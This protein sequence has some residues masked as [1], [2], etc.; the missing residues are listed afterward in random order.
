MEHASLGKLHQPVREIRRRR[1]NLAGDR[2][3]ATAL[4]A[5]ANLA[6]GLEQGL[7]FVQSFAVGRVGIAQFKTGSLGFLIAGAVVERQIS[8]GNAKGVIDAI[9]AEQEI[10]FLPDMYLGLW[11]EKV[12]GRKLTIWLG[13]CHVHAGIRPADI[14]RWQ[15]EAPDADL[16]VHP[17]CGCASQAMAF[18]NERT[19]ILSTEKMID[20]AK[21]SPKQRFLVAT[22]TGILHRL[23]REAPGKRFEAVRDDAECRYMKLTTLDKVRDSLRDM[24]HRVTVEPELA[25]RARLAIERMVAIA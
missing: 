6:I 10:L 21:R 19:Q 14:E 4:R 3:V 12:T 17:E 2:S 8:P 7:P 13:E 20:Y 24:K 18:G 5:M 11:L 25:G 1:G 15:E 22:E 16:L 23:Q 9:P